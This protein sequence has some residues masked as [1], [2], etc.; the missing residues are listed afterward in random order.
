MDTGQLHHALETLGAL[1]EYRGEH[2][3]IVLIGGGALLLLGLIERPTQDLDIVS[4]VEGERWVEGEPLPDGLAKAIAEVATTLALAP[5]WLNPG[6]SFLNEH[7][8]P[9]GFSDRVLIRRYQG[10]TI[11]LAARV[12]QITFKL[13]AAVNEGPRSK[14]F[15][16]LQR[17]APSQEELLIGARW[18]QN[19][20]T[21]PRFH[22]TLQQTLA[23]FGCD[24]V[25]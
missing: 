11:R 14:H 4:R 12:D 24:D 18:C 3:D 19:H 21:W 7:G 9:S 13:L 6:P 15:R 8:L 25:S 23:A 1:L 20:N 10:L 22:D 5:D 16:D 17:L 2:Y